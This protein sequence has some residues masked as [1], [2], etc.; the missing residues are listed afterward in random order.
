MISAA[1]IVLQLTHHAKHSDNL[2]EFI[3]YL[4]EAW[5]E[6]GLGSI[7]LDE[8][9]FIDLPEPHTEEYKKLLGEKFP[10]KEDLKTELEKIR[11]DAFRRV[12]G[13]GSLKELQDIRESLQRISPEDLKVK[14]EELRPQREAALE[15]RLK[16]Y[17][18]TPILERATQ[19]NF[20]RDPYQIPPDSLG[21]RT[22]FSDSSLYDEVC[23]TCG[24]TDTSWCDKLRETC[25][26][27]L[28]SSRE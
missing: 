25:P 7:P 18:T 20:G 26:S 12:W 14:M 28:P 11:K 4:E 6:V 21:H 16:P 9:G 1:E 15:E 13:T 19:S 5:V 17:K 3:E 27:P 10:S 24:A 2:S 23:V 22:R 8:S